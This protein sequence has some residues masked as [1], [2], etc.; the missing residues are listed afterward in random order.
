M[1]EPMVLEFGSTCFATT[2]QTVP[3]RGM[4]DNKASDQLYLPLRVIS[5]SV[6]IPSKAPMLFVIRAAD[7]RFC[8]NN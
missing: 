5:V 8:F 4:L 6:M 3:N 2:S 1:T 7:D